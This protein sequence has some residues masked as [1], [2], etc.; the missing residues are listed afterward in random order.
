MSVLVFSAQDIPGLSTPA[1]E[2]AQ[3]LQSKRMAAVSSR[4]Q[5]LIDE[6][7]TH[8]RRGIEGC[9]PLPVD[10]YFH[11]LAPAQAMSITGQRVR[12]LTEVPRRE[13]L[14]QRHLECLSLLVSGGKSCRSCARSV[15]ARSVNLACSAKGG[16]QSRVVRWGRRATDL[17]VLAVSQSSYSRATRWF[18]FARRGVCGRACDRMWRDGSLAVM[19]SKMWFGQRSIRRLLSD[20]VEYR[21]V[22]ANAL[23]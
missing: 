18:S 5:R 14:L 21:V 7:R 9:S 16:W 23:E 22:G 10:A 17:S 3:D 11:M 13:F 19:R 4:R 8:H 2:L 6:H 15:D 20:E 1:D 12:R